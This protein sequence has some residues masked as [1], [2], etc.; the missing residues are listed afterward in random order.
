MSF[1]VRLGTK[2]QHF[3]GTCEKELYER[4]HEKLAKLAEDPFPMT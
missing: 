2:A 4:I 3:L 1:E